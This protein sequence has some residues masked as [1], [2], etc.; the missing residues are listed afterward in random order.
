[1]AEVVFGKIRFTQIE[2]KPMLSFSVHVNP[3]RLEH[4]KLLQ[5]FKHFELT[6][7]MVH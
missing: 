6:F 2:N 4:K 3:Q 5:F 7:F 1:M